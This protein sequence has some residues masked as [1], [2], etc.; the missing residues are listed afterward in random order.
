MKKGSMLFFVAVLSAMSCALVQANDV[1]TLRSTTA[2]N[3]P[4][5]VNIFNPGQEV[6]V[7]GLGLLPNTW[8]HVWIVPDQ[9]NWIIGMPIPPQVP[10]T[11]KLAVLTDLVGN[12]PINL[13][14]PAA[15]PGKYDIIADCQQAGTLLRFDVNDSLDD[16]ETQGAAGFFVIPQI[17][18]GTIMALFACFAAFYMK[19]KKS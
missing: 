6:Y 13:I 18:L 7:L 8:Y 11:I 14:W 16:F 3:P 4:D 5:E 2:A 1:G 9:L 10:G 19:R 15:V 12:F 17:P